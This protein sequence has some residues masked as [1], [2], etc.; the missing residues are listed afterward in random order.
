MTV[1]IKTDSVRRG[2]VLRTACVVPGPLDEVFSFFSDAANLE[3]LM[4][5]HLKFQVLTPGPIDMHEGQRIDYR[6]R[7][8]GIPLRWTSEITVW[9]PP[10][11]FVDEQRRGP[12]RYWRH[13][14]S[15]E[16][17]EA[18]TRVL[19]QVRYGVPGGALVHWLAARRDIERIFAYR[20][21][22]LAELF[23]AAE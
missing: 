11:R 16:G 2:Y 10:H 19:D 9:E 6:L 1:E 5:A 12:Y 22:V 8:R 3:K 7:V 13:E 18:G 14:H 20:Q 4:P 17:C 15:F 21:Q 23:S